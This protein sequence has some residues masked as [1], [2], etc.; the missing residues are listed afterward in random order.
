MIFRNGR[1]QEDG[2][3][4]EDDPQPDRTEAAEQD[5]VLLLLGRQARLAIAMTTA[6]RRSA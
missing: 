4:R 5:R 6:F 2:E 3:E 1:R